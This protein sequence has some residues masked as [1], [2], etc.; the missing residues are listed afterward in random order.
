MLTDELIAFGATRFLTVRN[1]L[2]CKLYTRS[3]LNKTNLACL[4]YYLTKISYF[5][6]PLMRRS[7]EGCL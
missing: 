3:L 1:V 6:E 2:L 4:L 5:S 7:S